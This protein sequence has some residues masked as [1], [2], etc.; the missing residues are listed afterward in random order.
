MELRD[1]KDRLSRRELAA[2]F[3][4]EEQ[5]SRSASMLGSLALLGAGGL[6]GAI[7]ALFV[8]P[9]AGA[10]LRDDVGA[11]VRAVGTASSRDT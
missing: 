6:V 3:G 10:G 8:A 9:K 2:L 1:L 11:S 5:P 7:A 4:F